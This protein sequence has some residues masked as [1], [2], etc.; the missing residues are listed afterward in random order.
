MGLVD[1]DQNPNDDGDPTT[2]DMPSGPDTNDEIDDDVPGGGITLPEHSGIPLEVT[3]DEVLDFDEEPDSEIDVPVVDLSKLTEDFVAKNGDILTG[4]LKANVKISIAP[5]ATVTLAGATING[6]KSEACMW[7]GITCLGDATIILKGGT[8]NFVQGSYWIYPGIQ[9]AHNPSGPEYTLTIKGTGSL[10]AT[11]TGSACGIGGGDGVSSCGN[12]VIQGGNITAYGGSYTA[13]IGS[14]G[15]TSCSCGSI[16]ITGGTIKATGSSWAAAIGNGSGTCGDITITGGIVEATGGDSSAGIGGSYDST[17][18]TITITNDV[19][20][21]TA[22][23]GKD[24]S[25][26]IGKGVE[27]SCGTVTIG[28]MVYWDGTNYQNG[29]DTYLTTSPLIIE[30]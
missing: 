14:S 3:V 20:S 27:D 21:V 16:T 8:K 23:K 30:P 25:N 1:K 22:T 5:G 13:A 7:A 24:A 28:G 29:G 12:I 4:T 17:C 2:D 6:V 11:H 10:T 9:P 26:S 15:N 18:G 19:A